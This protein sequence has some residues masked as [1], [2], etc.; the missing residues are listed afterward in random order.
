[1]SDAAAPGT[2]IR[3]L[4]RSERQAALG[5]VMADGAAYVSLVMLAVEHDA[6]PLLLLSDLADHT[7]NLRREPRVSLLIDGTSGM[8]SPLAGARAT[9][10]G[11]IE[12]RDDAR[13]L[14]RYTARHPDAAGY[15]GFADFNL[16]RVTV[17]RAHLVA[18]F[19]RI[20]WVDAT[21]V[22]WPE[23]PAKLTAVEAEIIAHMNEDHGDAVQ[24]YAERLLDRPS[25]PWR[26][27]GIDPEG[28]D[29]ASERGSARLWFDQPVHDA[30]SA[31]VELVRLA[32]RARAAVG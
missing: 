29:L 32:R 8:Q 16:Y 11:R 4:L 6:S 27:A 10:M 24:L 21:D 1:M 5:T 14:A 22:L 25:G 9:I 17:E 3:R 30:A 28:A 13:A 20:H 2:V 26:L 18:G 12:R 31:R 19:G 23:T 7:K 15:A